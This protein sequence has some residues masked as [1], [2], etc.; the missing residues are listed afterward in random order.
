MR[1]RRPLARDLLMAAAAFL[2]PDEDVGGKT[3]L[4]HFGPG[5]LGTLRHLADHHFRGGRP[6]PAGNLDR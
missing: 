5:L 3:V 1:R 4:G 6:C 2:H